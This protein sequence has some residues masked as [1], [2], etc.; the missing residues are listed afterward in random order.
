MWGRGTPLRPHIL[1]I[2]PGVLNRQAAVPATSAMWPLMGVVGL[3]RNVSLARQTCFSLVFS[4]RGRGALNG[5]RP[6]AH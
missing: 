4:R 5:G 1:L 3:T 2:Y 6:L